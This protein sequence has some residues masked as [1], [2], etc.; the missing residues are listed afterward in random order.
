MK[1]SGEL[2]MIVTGAHIAGGMERAYEIDT[3]TDMELMEFLV[4]SYNRYMSDFDST[5]SFAEYIERHLLE[6]FGLDN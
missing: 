3:G 6:T 5:E 4:D 2:E 1:T